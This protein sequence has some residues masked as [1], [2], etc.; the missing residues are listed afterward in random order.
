MKLQIRLLCLLAACWSVTAAA[1]PRQMYVDGPYGQIHLRIDGPAAGPPVILLHKMFWSAVQFEHVQGVLA[2]RGIFSVAV[3]IPGYG[4][5]DAPPAEPTT[6]Q[7][8]AALVPVFD[9]L[10]IRRAFVLGVDTGSSV[11]LAFADQYPERVEALILDGAPIFDAATARKLIDA[12]HF[13]R[14][15]L[16]G[17]ETLARRWQAVRSIIGP[18]QASDANVQASVLQFFAASPNWWW[19]HDAI[20]KY[21][22]ATALKRVKTSGM[23]LSFPGGALHTQEA[24]FMAIRP[25][26]RLQPIAVGAYTTPSY[27]A[28]GVWA[29]AV[30]DYM[31]DVRPALVER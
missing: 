25:D 4:G 27:D 21:D 17:G 22:F 10:K 13:D 20:F 6:A 5:S 30:A 29:A 19:A 31:L 16:P 24:Q 3:D 1:K 15:P 14:T 28:P 7:Y 18:D 9:S 11:A 8:A 12:P 23:L 26:F 2:D